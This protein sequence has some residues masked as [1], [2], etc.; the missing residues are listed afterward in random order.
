M[1]EILHKADKNALEDYKKE[2]TKG[3]LIP[4]EEVYKMIFG[5]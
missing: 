3:K 2:K 4:Q 1:D 5:K